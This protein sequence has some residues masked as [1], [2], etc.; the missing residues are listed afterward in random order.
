MDFPFLTV[1]RAAEHVAGLGIHRETAFS[2]A[3]LYSGGR[4]GWAYFGRS[5]GS[6]REFYR[7]PD[8]FN[9]AS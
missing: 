5:G 6:L 7:I 2:T 3:N 9:Y 4:G 8:A 1:G